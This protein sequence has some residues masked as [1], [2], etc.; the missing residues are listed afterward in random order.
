[1]FRIYFIGFLLINNNCLARSSH[2]V[3]GELKKND[4]YQIILFPKTLSERILKVAF[5]KKEEQKMSLMAKAELFANSQVKAQG[6]LIPPQTFEIENLNR[7][8][9]D[10]LE[11]GNGTGIWPIRK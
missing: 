1:M 7:S 3:I 4:G 10:P 11:P 8:V 5:P 2:L 6:R 9:P